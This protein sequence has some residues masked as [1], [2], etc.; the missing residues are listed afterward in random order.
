MFYDFLRP[1]QNMNHNEF[2]FEL[3]LSVS[4]LRLNTISTSRDFFNDWYIWK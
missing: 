4:E 1:C 2:F 3:Y